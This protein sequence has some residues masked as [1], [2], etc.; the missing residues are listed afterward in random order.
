[1]D[2]KKFKGFMAINDIKQSEIA[3]T[4]GISLENANAKINGRQKFTLEQV[5]ILCQKYQISADHYFI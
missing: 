3:E 1:M 4:L 5:K 2:D